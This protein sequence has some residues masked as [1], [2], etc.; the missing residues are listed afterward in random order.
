MRALSYGPRVY[1]V[2]SVHKAVA[3]RALCGSVVELLDLAAAGH[4]HADLGRAEV[5]DIA[6][7]GDRDLEPLA[8]LHLGIATAG[9]GDL[10]L[11]GLQALG[12]DVA[13]TGHRDVEAA[14]AAMGDHITAA[15]D[16]DAQALAVELVEDDVAR[17]GDAGVH[18][19]GLHGLD[20][21]VA[22]AG[23]RDRAQLGYVEHDLR[24]GGGVQV[25]AALG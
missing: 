11:L 20:L 25:V 5:A 8:G 7:A 15:R 6:R 19:R 14:G 23:D 18:P 13:R 24:R 1:A 10:D 3:Q 9:D 17:A 2:A 4:R 21:D 12:L 16:L 22:R